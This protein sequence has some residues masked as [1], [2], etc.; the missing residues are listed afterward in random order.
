M[1]KCRIFRERCSFEE[2][3]L[4]FDVKANRRIIPSQLGE[5]AEKIFA[6]RVED[7]M[8]LVIIDTYLQQALQ[9][10]QQVGA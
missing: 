1:D 7:P 3:L 6:C 2:E 8:A 9:R 4:L 5:I 10:T